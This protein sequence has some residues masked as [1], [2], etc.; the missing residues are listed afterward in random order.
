MNL[1]TLSRVAAG[2]VSVRHVG[3]HLRPY[4]TRTSRPNSS[5]ARLDARARARRT[6]S[7]YTAAA[8]WHA[9]RGAG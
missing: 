4:L 3:L 5:A 9:P 7:L 6:P 1:A 8:A 2:A